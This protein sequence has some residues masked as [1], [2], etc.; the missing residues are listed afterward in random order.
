MQES[1]DELRINSELSERIEYSRAKWLV[2][3]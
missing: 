3:E 1:I 2:I